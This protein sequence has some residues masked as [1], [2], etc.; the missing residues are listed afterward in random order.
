MRVRDG[1]LRIEVRNQSPENRYI[2]RILFDG[3]PYRN[4]YI[5]YADIAGGGELVFEM[6]P[7]PADWTQA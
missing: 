4:Y 6:G 7:E 3:A 2:R 1:V 5:D